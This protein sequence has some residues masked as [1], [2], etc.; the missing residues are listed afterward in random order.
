[1]ISSTVPQ[2]TV[3]LKVLE[4]IGASADGYR[5]RVGVVDPSGA[6]HFAVVTFARNEAGADGLEW[7]WDVERSHS[8]QLALGVGR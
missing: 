6:M 2:Q 1:M 5:M 8:V 4:V 3:N 7:E